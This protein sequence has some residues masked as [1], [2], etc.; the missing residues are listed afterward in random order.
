MALA[1]TTGRLNALQE[2]LARD[3]DRFVALFAE[4]EN[5]RIAVETANGRLEGT[6]G[7]LA[8]ARI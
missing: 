2:N 5:T 7:E 4:L 3:K 6:A 8:T 1:G